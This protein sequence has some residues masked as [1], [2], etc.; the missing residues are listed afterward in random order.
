M[1]SSVVDLE[2]RSPDCDCAL[3]DCWLLM[4]AA[5]VA[6][7]LGAMEVM[8]VAAVGWRLKLKN[9]PVEHD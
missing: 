8:A 5:E 4:E 9:A 7:E 2:D 3:S 6:R 1:S